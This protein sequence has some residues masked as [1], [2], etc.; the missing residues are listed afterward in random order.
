M[1]SIR[2]LVKLVGEEELITYKYGPEH[3]NTQRLRGWS[4]EALQLCSKM[5]CFDKLLFVCFW[6]WV[7]G[8]VGFV[9]ILRWKFP[10][11]QRVDGFRTI[12]NW[13]TL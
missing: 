10:R 5:T 3:V 6:S 2:S 12:Y 9:G 13:V 8:P 1:M 7:I 11:K 4:A